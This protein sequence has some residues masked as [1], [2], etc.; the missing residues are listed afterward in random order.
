MKDIASRKLF[1]TIAIMSVG[2]S[3]E[4]FIHLIFHI[5]SP[6]LIPRRSHI[7]RWKHIF[8]AHSTAENIYSWSRRPPDKNPT[9]RGQIQAGGRKRRKKNEI[10]VYLF[11]DVC[12]HCARVC[13]VSFRVPSNIHE[14]KHLLRSIKNLLRK[15]ILAYLLGIFHNFYVEHVAMVAIVSMGEEMRIGDFQS[16]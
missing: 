4:L 10:H 16:F 12:G 11:A 2:P 3:S 9:M 13:C 7:R 5:I 15:F 14:S 1:L 8:R 6:R